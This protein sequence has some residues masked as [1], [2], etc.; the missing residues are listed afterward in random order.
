[1]FI[2]FFG[3]RPG[4]TR[5]SHLPG[6]SCPFCS[7][8]GQ[9]KARIQPRYIHIFWIPVYRLSP[10]ELIQCGHCKKAYSKGDCSHEMQEALKKLKNE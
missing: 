9:L 7:Q 4:K 6:V 10:S 2:L 5:E 8:T 3:T 1:M